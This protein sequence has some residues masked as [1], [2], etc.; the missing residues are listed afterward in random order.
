[1]PLAS[2]LVG[3][4]DDLRRLEQ[5]VAEHPLV[6]VV[7]PGGVGKTSLVLALVDRLSSADGG[8]V[9][10]A[11]LA[12]LPP[13]AEPRDV[14][15]A[16]GFESLDAATLVLA[17]R[18]GPIVLDNCEHVLDAVRPV[19]EAVRVC[20]PGVAVVA[21]SRETLR[22][23]G[24]QVVVVPP[25]AL[26]SPGGA[27]AEQVPAV[28]L[29]LARAAAA[30]ASL[31]PGPRLLA[32][33]GELCRRL[34]GLP[35]AI[36]LAAARTRAIAP[37]ELLAVLDERLDVLRRSRGSG[38]RHDS[39]RAAIEVSTAL[40]TRPERELFRRLGV[41]S[42][43]FDLGLAHAVAGE[44]G[45][46]RLASLDLLASLVD[47]SLVTATVD[48]SGG[49]YRL[50]ELLRAHAGDELHA[51][52][53]VAEVE[54]RF[55]VGMLVVA[56]R[57]VAEALTRWD[58]MVLEAAS[59]QF[60][61][62]VRAVELCLDRDPDPARAYRLVLPMFAAV[63]EG[64][65]AEVAAV[66]ARVLDRWDTED[67]PWRAEVI[68]VL[69]TAAALAGWGPDAVA[70]ARRVA[71]D[72]EAGP[73]AVA[74]AERAWG[75][76]ARAD[77]PEEAAAHFERARAAALQAGFAPIAREVLVFEAGQRAVMG[78]GDAAMHLLDDALDQARSANDPFA[79]VPAHLV[80]ALVLLRAGD[81]VAAGQEVE[82]AEVDAATT[83]HPW[84][85]AALLR[86]AAAVASLGPQGWAPSAARWRRAV[87]FAA[88]RGALGEMGITL[89]AAASVALHLG[90]REV[91][92]LLFAA[93]PPVSN[94]T[95]LPELF[96]DAVATL[97]VAAPA[98]P[99]GTNLIDALARARAALDAAVER[100]GA[101]A[102]AGA[103][104]AAVA[105]GGPQGSLRQEGDSWA[106]T[107]AGRSV[108][109]KDMKGLHD[110]AVLLDR[111]GAEVHS[112]HLM[113][114]HDVGT[115][116]GPSLDDT[117]RQAYQDRIV[118]LQREIE[119][120]RDAN[121]PARAERAELEL[122]ALVEQLSE[123]FGLGGRARATGSSAE[124]ART[125]VTY[126][127]RAAIKKVGE[128]HPDL[129]R[130][131]ANS[132]RTGT[133]CSYQPETDTGWDVAVG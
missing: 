78:D 60:A 18:S 47:R 81:V 3:R 111:P 107:W 25:L 95:V 26:P 77:D 5:A 33:V 49:H 38:D 118:D 21:T 1:M 127:V 72:P 39:M 41:F 14:V 36:E 57:V 42:G 69:A 31:S 40:L 4:D 93:V 75:I 85:T 37:S 82:R 110:L 125:A 117:A 105:V 28:Q 64:R 65:P 131:L 99:T 97:R 12:G 104:S 132:V 120:A 100:A 16:L 52:G 74:L 86:T 23:P 44:P 128:L 68:G 92:E 27:D 133:W 71:A 96:P 9:P 20:C 62:L 79:S 89:R 17:G 11:L 19:V 63:H 61:N 76:V 121:D 22:I 59:G 46:D 10:V 112:L 129:G 24:E 116:V 55:V 6:T 13:G 94:V 43:P 51:A 84:W 2:P 83:G 124:R 98:G 45:T 48:G 102:A 88:S 130:H 108:R 123:A 67:Q 34:D 58:P 90:E 114:G 103:T 101:S 15:V 80:R 8:D 30:G 7:G 113:G 87:D 91:A 35:L 54:E 56:D 32:D 53:E 29:F 106:V 115:A 126:R 70:H 122:D 50:L 73:V 109:C 66:G 119:E